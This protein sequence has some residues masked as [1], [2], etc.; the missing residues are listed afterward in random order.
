MGLMIAGLGLSHAAPPPWT[1]VVRSTGST[2]VDGDCRGLGCTTTADTRRDECCPYTCPLLGTSPFDCLARPPPRTPSSD[3][4]PVGK[5]GTFLRSCGRLR[6]ARHDRAATRIYNHED[7]HHR[8]DSVLAPLQR[9]RELLLVRKVREPGYGSRRTAGCLA[10]R[11]RVRRSSGSLQAG[12][13]RRTPANAAEHTAPAGAGGA[14]GGR[15]S[16]PPDSACA[17]RHLRMARP[18]CRTRPPASPPPLAGGSDLCTDGRS[19]RLRMSCATL[20]TARRVTWRKRE[21]STVE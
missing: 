5:G 8:L 18:G 17:P 15:P 20:A 7:H 21:P 10:G 9:P 2:W 4:W 14:A 12:L 19:L 11:L 3:P 6:G 1:L 13:G 16:V